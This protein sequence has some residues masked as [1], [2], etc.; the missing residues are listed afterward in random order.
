MTSR[1]LIAAVL[2]TLTSASLAIG[3][4]APA[5]AAT[6]SARSLLFKISVAFENNASYDRA[7][8]Q[9]WIDANGDCQNT[10]AEVLV[11]E[12]LV[13]V[14]YTSSN[15]CYVRS[16]KWV[17]KW[18]GRT[19]TNPADVDIDHHVALAEAWGSGA[20]YWSSTD[21]HRYSNDLY[22]PNLNAITDNLNS[23]KG[24]SDPAQWLPPLTSSRCL[25]AIYW[26][27]I[28]YRWRLTMDSAERTKLSGILS[29]TCGSRTVTIPARAR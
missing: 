14:S 7:K 25:Y 4:A 13:P 27:Q 22:Y 19:W 15:R 29:G 6:T 11:S 21:R 26:V 9:D 1:R 2:A 20:R 23:S 5:E 3:A 28:K 8:F 12:S 10:R 16:G 17:S 18:D 24:A